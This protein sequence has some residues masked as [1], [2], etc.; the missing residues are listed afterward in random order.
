M[1]LEHTEL[2]AVT[3]VRPRAK[4]RIVVTVIDRIAEGVARTERERCTEVSDYQSK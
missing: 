4:R 1:P 2:A 3:V